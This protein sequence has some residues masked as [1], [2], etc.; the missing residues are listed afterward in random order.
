[1]GILD[2]GIQYKRPG[3]ISEQHVKDWINEV[4]DKEGDFFIAKSIKDNKEIYYLYLDPHHFKIKADKKNIYVSGIKR[5]ESNSEDK[6]IFKITM[7][8]KRKPKAIIINGTVIPTKSIPE[9]GGK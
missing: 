9:I 1:M 7:E 3:E 2:F 6:R 4:K 5:G 8:E